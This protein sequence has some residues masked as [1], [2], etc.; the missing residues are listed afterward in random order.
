MVEAIAL[1]TMAGGEA[2]IVTHET[3]NVLVFIGKQKFVI[4]N[5]LAYP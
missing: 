4:K 5:L 1:I 3:T 2:N